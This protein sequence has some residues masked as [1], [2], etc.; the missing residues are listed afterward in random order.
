MVGIGTASTVLNNRLDM[1]SRS[2]SFSRCFHSSC[3]K[4]AWYW[5]PRQSSVPALYKIRKEP[6]L[7]PTMILVGIMPVFTFAL[8]TWQLQRLRWK[9]NL[10]D[11]LE[12]KLELEPLNL[13]PKIKF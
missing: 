7:T 13:P 8:G 3:S 6:W 11:E 5:R 10:I 4:L 12:E 9:I 1:F 2:F